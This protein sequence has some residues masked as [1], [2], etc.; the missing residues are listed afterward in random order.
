MAKLLIKGGTL[1]SEGA[2]RKGDILVAN[3]KIAAIGESLSADAQTEVFDAEGCIVT[4]G[5]ADV[6]VHLREPGYSAKETITTGTRA[7]A[8]GGVTTVCAM[9][10]LQ[11]A[12][13]APETISIEQRMID[14]Q[15]VVE[16]LPFATIS[17]GRERR[18]LAEIEALRPLSVGYSDDGNGI[19]TEGLMRQAMQRIAAVD[20]IIAAHCEDDALLHAGY[21]HDGE[22]ARQHG[23]K[24]IC[25]ESEWGPIKRDVKLAEEEKCRYHV[26]H[27]STKESV[28]IIREAKQ[29]CSHIS[30][31]TAPHYLILCDA[32]LKEEGRFKMNPPLRSAEDRAALIEGIKD[33]TIE[34]IATDHAPHTAEEKSR[35]LKGSAM[36][37]VGIETAFA[38]CYTHLVRKGVIT[39]EK[40]VALMSEN[41]RRLFRLGGALREGERADIALF[42]TTT[43]YTIDTA[44][45]LSMGKATPFE[46]EEVYGRCRLTLFAGEKVYEDTKNR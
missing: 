29:R 2:S 19:Q 27:I 11:P 17:K 4:Y 13:D 5:L 26:C 18:E 43:P 31:E 42:D 9:P 46:G 16:V 10:N 41:P 21:I 6:H 39:I 32:D 8:H 35:G 37:I 24:G 1:V 33:G 36:G 45:F 25:S 14:E 23:H 28:E 20:G 3:G 12:P 34:V 22:Y 7:A 30:C 40:L 44:E 38:L 15:A